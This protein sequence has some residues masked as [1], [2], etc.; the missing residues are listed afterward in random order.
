[1]LR[2][3]DAG[4]E[5]GTVTGERT[6]FL[7]RH[8]EL[9]RATRVELTAQRRHGLVDDRDEHRREQTRDAEIATHLRRGET[10]VLGGLLLCLEGRD[11]FLLDL[12]LR[13]CEFLVELDLRLRELLVDLRLGL[14]CPPVVLEPILRD[15][16]G[17]ELRL[18]PQR[19][20]FR[21]ASRATL[22]CEQPH[23][24]APSIRYDTTL[25][26]PASA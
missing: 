1:L 15:Q 6:Q 18:G 10:L 12:G 20:R 11:L 25:R 24:T 14:R 17:L 13:P 5:P 22:P 23:R 8:P 7:D 9:L 21:P 2:T 4:T 19:L 16:S 3:R 26:R